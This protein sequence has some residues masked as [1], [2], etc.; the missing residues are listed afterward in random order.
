MG[1]TNVAEGD[2]LQVMGE[3][4]DVVEKDRYYELIVDG[5]P[6]Y[7]MVIEI[8]GKK[9][10]RLAGWQVLVNRHWRYVADLHM[11]IWKDTKTEMSVSEIAEKYGC[12]S[13]MVEDIRDNE[14]GFQDGVLVS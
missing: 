14:R 9:Y 11:E 2:R 5:V 4:G 7:R 10:Q 13:R 3:W 1:K 6:K 8:P 12:A